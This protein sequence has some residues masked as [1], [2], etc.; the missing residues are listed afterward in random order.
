MAA[1]PL[2]EVVDEPIHLLLSTLPAAVRC[3]KDPKTTLVMQ[4]TS[5]A[6]LATCPEC[7]RRQSQERKAG[8]RG[9]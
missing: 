4:V 7:R 9:R 2:A 6:L 3:G 5:L 8:S 1:E